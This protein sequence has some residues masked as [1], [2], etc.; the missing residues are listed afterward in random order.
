MI[1]VVIPT[2]NRAER[3]RPSLDSVTTSGAQA[4]FP[5]ELIV[6]DNNS[7]DETAE[8]V[9][10][11]I[12]AHPNHAVT[13][14]FEPQPGVSA[15]RNR[16]IAIAQYPII[17]F[18]DDDCFVAT[19]W[20][21]DIRIAFEQ[22][23]DHLLVSGRVERHDERDALTAT[24]DF[25][26]WR[27]IETVGEIRAY[28]IGC[29]HAVAREVFDK[30]GA[31]DTGFGKPGPLGTGEDHELFYRGLRSGFRVAYDP[32]IR[33]RH[34]H[35]RRTTDEVA[36]VNADYIRG[37]G[38]LLGKHFRRGDRDLLKPAYWEWRQLLLATLS[39]GYKNN[40]IKRPLWNF[41]VGLTLGF[42]DR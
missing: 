15:A 11:F 18:V 38:G 35:G 31:Y 37:Y 9:S 30:I 4:Q 39:G 17:A 36:A 10:E 3:L 7:T 12:R 5:W 28:T 16:G 40:P 24:R 29:N 25:D 19:S 21:T 14:V 33:V 6:V 13:N 32:T 42:L 34:A 27:E 20:L 2:C 26:E 1:S 41:S 22:R 23:P 8:V